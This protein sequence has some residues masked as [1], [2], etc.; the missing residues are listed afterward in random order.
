M[1]P[2]LLRLVTT[3]T[4]TT[5]IYPLSIPQYPQS[6]LPTKP[7]PITFPLPNYL[8]A[9]TPKLANQ[10]LLTLISPFPPQCKLTINPILN[11][12]FG[13]YPDFVCLKTK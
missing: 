3:S 5:S 12:I 10:T 13:R 7:Q 9:L 8:Q 6:P 4:P 1:S 2:A 11:S